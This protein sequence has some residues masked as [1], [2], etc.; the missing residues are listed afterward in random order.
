MKKYVIINADDYG[1][2]EN[3]NKGIIKTLAQGVVSDLSI[4]ATGKAFNDGVARLRENNIKEIG[5]HVCLSTGLKP[6]TMR[7]RDSIKECTRLKGS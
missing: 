3:I 2:S 5:V 6:L 1:Y 4:M 7:A